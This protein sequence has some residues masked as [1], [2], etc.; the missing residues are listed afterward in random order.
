MVKI[1]YFIIILSS[2]SSLY[3]MSPERHINIKDLWSR[4]IKEPQGRKCWSGLEGLQRQ[5]EMGM[6]RETLQGGG[7]VG[8][9]SK[10]LC[11]LIILVLT[12]SYLRFS[13]YLINII[14]RWLVQDL[15]IT[16]E[17][18]SVSSEKK[19]RKEKVLRFSP[20]CPA[21]EKVIF[22]L[23]VWIKFFKNNHLPKD[24]KA[25]KLPLDSDLIKLENV[26]VFMT[27]TIQI[28]K[29]KTWTNTAFCLNMNTIVFKSRCTYNPTMA[30]SA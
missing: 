30:K 15:E 3:H 8:V 5:R 24:D 9:R 4:R 27:I 6:G 13:Y 11:F 26:C 14:S 25:T 20:L 23:S 10:W 18:K 7:F 21:Q 12:H 17:H 29:W 22:R 28:K 19:N 1:F 16:L 2:I